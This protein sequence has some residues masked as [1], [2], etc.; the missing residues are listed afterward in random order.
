MDAREMALRVNIDQKRVLTLSVEGGTE[1][2]RCRCFS[3]TAF[4]VEDG[5]PHG[6]FILYKPLF[7]T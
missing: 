5:N 3:D 6:F 7:F 1:V 2:E 4:L